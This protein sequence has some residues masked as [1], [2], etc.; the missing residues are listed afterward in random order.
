MGYI[1]L[2]FNLLRYCLHM[3]YCNLYGILNVVIM[4]IYY[5]CYECYP[6]T[7]C[8]LFHVLCM[9]LLNSLYE[10]QTCVNF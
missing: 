2:L 10:F 6:A 8:L 4:D 9:G 1:K 3:F 7:I 5:Y